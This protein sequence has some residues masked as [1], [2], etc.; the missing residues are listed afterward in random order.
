MEAD[1][2]DDQPCVCAHETTRGV[3]GCDKREPRSL[4]RAAEGRAIGTNLRKTGG[5]G[6]GVC[7][8]RA[9]QRRQGVGAAFHA[10]AA[11]VERASVGGVCACHTDLP[12]DRR[13]G[14]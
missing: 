8:G 10:R 9:E 7:G 5:R 13:V 11:R 3:G 14:L 6:A 2:E 12:I 4:K 1:E